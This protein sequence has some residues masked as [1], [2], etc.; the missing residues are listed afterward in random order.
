MYRCLPLSN[1]IFSLTTDALSNVVFNGFTMTSV[2]TKEEDIY[3]IHTK[4][5]NR[6]H[7]G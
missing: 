2:L 1:C 7:T 5:V 3:G 6:L 4:D